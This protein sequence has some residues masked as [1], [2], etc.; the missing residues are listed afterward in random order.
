MKSFFTFPG[1]FLAEDI[2]KTWSLRLNYN[3]CTFEANSKSSTLVNILN[4]LNEIYATKLNLNPWTNLMGQING[5][6]EKYLP[7]FKFFAHNWIRLFQGQ[8]QLKRFM[9]RT[10]S[11][12]F[13]K[14]IRDLIE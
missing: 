4:I 10:K 12:R 14:N 7:D 6:R 3:L 8:K 5:S 2:I 1:L 11:I 9:S 13:D